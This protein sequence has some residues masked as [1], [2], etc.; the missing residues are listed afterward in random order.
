LYKVA[1]LRVEGWEGKAREFYN[2]PLCAMRI[3]L[4]RA[5]SVKFFIDNWFLIAAALISGGMLL[6]PLLQRGVSGGIDTVA[7]VM[8]VNREKGVLIDVS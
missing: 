5:P 4:P 2:P 7:A 6:W 1:L 8:L 3:T